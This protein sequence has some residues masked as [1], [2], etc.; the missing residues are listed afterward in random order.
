MI[1]VNLSAIPPAT[2]RHAEQDRSAATAHSATSSV[3]A[4]FQQRLHR[5]D[6]A[7][8]YAKDTQQ[9]IEHLLRHAVTE[10]QPSLA[11]HISQRV[12]NSRE[13][14][15]DTAL[16]QDVEHYLNQTSALDPRKSYAQLIHDIIQSPPPDSSNV[17]TLLPRSRRALQNPGSAQETRAVSIRQFADALVED[18]DRVLSLNFANHLIRRWL[19]TSSD[20]GF[21]DDKVAVPPE[22]TFGLAW[23]SLADTLHAEPFKTFAQTKGIDLSSL[24]IKAN[25]DLAA[26]SNGQTVSFSLARDPNWAS[27]SSAVLAAARKLPGDIRFHD[28]DHASADNIGTFYAVT[29]STHSNDTLFTIDQLLSG[30]AFDSLSSSFYYYAVQNAPVQQRQREAKQQVAQLPAQSLDRLIERFTPSTLVQKV[31]E[32]DRALARLCSQ[33]VAQ[34]FAPPLPALPEY[35]TFNQARKNLEAALGGSAFTN[36]VREK[37]L[38]VSSIRIH[39][40]DGTLKGT[41]K[42]VDTTFELNDLDWSAV[43]PEVQDAVKH[44]AGGST[45]DVAHPSAAP[46][47]LR[48]ILDFYAEQGPQPYLSN[49]ANL[50]RDSRKARLL[51]SAEI[52]RNGG[53]KSLVDAQA[54]SPRYHRVREAQQAVTLQL[55]GK[56]LILSPLETLAADVKR[57]TGSADSA[58]VT[59]PITELPEDARASAESALAVAVH[60]VMLDLQDGQDFAVSKRIESIPANTRFGQWWAHLGKALNGR[61]LTEWARQQNVDM[62]T[63]RFDPA[64]K[65]LIGKVNG[66]DQRFAASDFAQKY[67]DHFDALAHVVSAAEALVP[68]GKPI[69]LSHTRDSSAPYALIANFYGIDNAD[70][71]SAAFSNSVNLMGRTQRFPEQPEIPAQ[72]L[73]WLNRQKTALGDSNDRYALIDTLKG[74]NYSADASK[75][76]L[77][78]PDSS[79]QPK[80]PTTGDRFIADQGWYPANS[81]AQTQNLLLALKTPLPQSPALGNQWGFLSTPLPLSLEQ[82]STVTER[83]KASIGDF[84]T[85]ISYL[86][87]GVDELSTDPKLALEQLLSSDKGQALAQALQTTLKGA[88]TA[89]S[90]KQWLLTALVLDL[91]PSAGTTRNSVAGFDFMQPANWALGTDKICERFNRHLTSEKKIPTGLAPIAQQLLMSGMAP[92][93]LVKEVPQTVTLG[94]PEWAIFTTAVNRIELTAPGATAHMTY[95]QVMDV[96]KITPICA[97]ETTQLAIAQH[98]PLMDWAIINNHVVK[99]D[100]DEYTLEQM[101]SSREKLGKQIEETSDARKYLSRFQPPNRRAMALE[102]LSAK[103]GNDIDFESQYMLE[104]FAGGA[105]TGIRASLVEIYEAGRLGESWR[106][107]RPGVNFEHLRAQAHE[108]PNINEKFDTAIQEDFTPRRTHLIS[109]FKDM[110]SK[111]PL[112]E[113]NSLN[114]GAV[115]LLQ[116]EGAGSGIVMTSVYKGIRRDFAV[117]PATGQITRIADIDPST[118]LGQKVSLALD[119]QAFKNGTAPNP[120][121]KSEVVLR[122]SEQLILIESDDGDKRPE[123]R[124]RLF[125]ECT[126]GDL[127]PTY[128]GEMI[129]DL[130]KVLVDTTYLRKSEFIARYR[131]WASNAVETGTEPSDFFKGVLHALPGG[132]SLK[133]L[134]H[135]E[136]VKAGADL[137][138]DIAIY[139]AT[140]GAGKLWGVAKSGAAWA[141]A[142]TS[143]RFIEK[144]GTQEVEGIALKDITAANMADGTVARDA[145]GEK[146]KT[147]AVL[148]DGKWYAYDTQTMTAYGPALEGFVSETSSVMRHE[149]FSDGTQALVTEKPLAADAYTLARANGFDVVSEGKVYRYD[150]RNAGVLT[151]LESADHYKSPEGFE[152]VCPAP[153]SG[154]SRVRRGT[155]DTC[156]SKVIENTAGASAQELQALEHVRLF[157]SPKKLFGKDQFVVFERRRYKMIDGEMGP[158]LSPVLDKTPITYKTLI[159]GRI[160]PDPGFGFIGGQG[161]EVLAQQTRVVKLDN[162]SDICADSREVRGV[163]VKSPVAGSTDKYLVVEADT[164][165]FYYAKLSGTA[166][167]ELTFV[168]CTPKE[169]PLINDYRNAFNT[170]LDISRLPNDA[171][172][173]A[174]PKLKSAFAELERSGY[175]TAEVDKLKGYCKNLTAEQ[176]REVLYQLQR[177]GATGKT[178]IALRPNQ[179]LPLTKPD[180]FAAL[181][182]E[183]QNKFYAQQAKNSVNR[184]MKATGLGPSNQVRTATDQARANAANMVNQWLRNTVATHAPN[185]PNMILKAG[186]GNCGEMALVSKDTIVKSGGRAY[187]WF[188][189]DAHAFTVVG[190]PSVRP[191]GTVNF[192]QA[193]WADAWVVDPWADIACPA[194]EYTQ[195]LKEVMTQWERSGL[196]IRDSKGLISPLDKDWLDALITND[197]EP[198][199]HGYI[200]P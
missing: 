22:S 115:E 129:E 197:K 39:P 182:A 46:V 1:N 168:K 107:E 100:K 87:S 133:D 152:A 43:W 181:P 113:R 66:V 106:S 5:S 47:Q 28:R 151:D 70:R 124:E 117:Y 73:N 141:A 26:S 45:A 6:E 92:P 69:M 103:F 9:R 14:L 185:K 184:A 188:A 8:G 175:P 41:V 72:R 58:A 51:P 98:N 108:L 137:A 180:G 105:I 191:A 139:A 112:E 42:G 10:G 134:Y 165:E 166:S 48:D 198:Y 82:R 21:G 16:R 88:P 157:P 27:A 64:E 127:S 135:G 80:G 132:S 160:K 130:A 94:T 172:F 190:G 128:D 50:E 95:P 138:I 49:A 37:N 136:F 36:F 85:L 96:Q 149:T 121:A 2:V 83:V 86:A 77:V 167:G 161:S 31:Q 54:T 195:K 60:R 89:T 74:P 56:P 23:A 173:I 123:L 131:H 35:S 174:L 187:E 178:N 65:V 169:L 189:S 163:I 57:N 34:D 17:R 75:T 122:L 33:Q 154:V 76:F 177:S 170:R 13:P 111:L 25:G 200:N 30:V 93:F 91:D 19:A 146:I 18:G 32:A 90:L 126:G 102:A 68:N 12:Q 155:N 183:Q 71:T 84:A 7:S 192:S 15:T 3:I 193:I 62:T 153:A 176:Q 104:S 53:F 150:K 142:K 194:R 171:N 79:H 38:D 81:L 145:I 52:T 143:A 140:E 61:G 55:A 196:K 118:P 147:T 156:F 59:P 24:V 20:P 11:E 109:L 186:A 78:D 144:L 67:P 29:P 116:V 114:Y 44:A 101:N 99:N 199:P 162:I 179:V 120:N 159:N 164:A 4:L 63:L 40:V 125:L 148:Q 119:A 97:G 158:Q 110:L